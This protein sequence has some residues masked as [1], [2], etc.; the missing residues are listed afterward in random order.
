M[1]SYFLLEMCQWY[2]SFQAMAAPGNRNIAMAPSCLPPPLWH[3]NLVVKALI[4]N[5]AERGLISSFAIGDLDVYLSW[6]SQP[7]LS[8]RWSWGAEAFHA[9]Q[10]I[11]AQCRKTADTLDRGAGIRK[12]LTDHSTGG[13]RCLIGKRAYQFRILAPNAVW[14]HLL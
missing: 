4:Q 9:T 5:V 10:G 12:K 7:R 2:P 1:P 6:V 11:W 8:Y 13:C 14:I 3:Y